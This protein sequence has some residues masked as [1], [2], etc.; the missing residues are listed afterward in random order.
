MA[1]AVET[2]AFRQVARPE[3]AKNVIR[4]NSWQKLRPELKTFFLFRVHHTIR[5][6][7]HTFVRRTFPRTGRHFQID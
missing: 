4:T 3:N 2:L 5:A 6:R 1:K 7:T